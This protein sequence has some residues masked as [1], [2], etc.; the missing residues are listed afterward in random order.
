[1]N[2]TLGLLCVIC[3]LRGQNIGAEEPVVFPDANLKLA[4]ETELWV[5]DAMPSDMLLLTTLNANSRRISDLT[6][7]EYALNLQ[8]LELTHNKI[9]VVSPLMNLSFLKKLVLNNNKIQDLSPLSSLDNLEHLDLHENDIVDLSPLSSLTGLTH[10]NLH[11]NKISNIS[12]LSDLNRLRVLHLDW[13]QIRDLSGLSGLV[14]L[15]TL[16]LRVNF[17]RNISPL[18]N[19]TQ[20]RTLICSW[21]DVVDLTPLQ[22]LE[23]L[24]QLGLED[25]AVR[26]VTALQGLVKLRILVLAECPLKDISPLT[27]LKDLVHLDVSS[28][29]LN[30]TAYSEDMDTIIENNPGMT[31][32]YSPNKH[33]TE[34]VSITHEPGSLTVRWRP[35]SNGPRFTSYYRLC[36][37][38][39]PNSPK[40]PVSPWIKQTMFRDEDIPAKT[41]TYWVQTLATVP[42]DSADS[43]S[44][45]RIYEVPYQPSL[46]LTST[47]GGFYVS[48]IEDTLVYENDTL[49][50]VSA[51]SVDPN[52]YT[53][54]HWSGSAVDANRVTDVNLPET[55]VWVDNSY[56]LRAHFKSALNS[57]FVDVNQSEG[58]PEDGTETHPFDSIQAAIDVAQEGAEIK[59]RPGV[60]HETI[61]FLGKNVT[62]TGLDCLD[63]NQAELPIIDANQTGPVVSFVHGEDSNCLISGFV[64]TRGLG[65]VVCR[66]SSPVVA[67]CLVVGND[68]DLSS[69]EAAIYCQNSQAVF[70]QCTVTDNLGLGFHLEQSQVTL[71]HSIAWHNTR[72]DILRDIYSQPEVTFCN[73]GFLWTLGPGNQGNISE[74][75]LFASRGFWVELHEET[76]WIH[77]DYHLRSRRGRWS[78]LDGVWVLD[79]TDSPCIDA[80]NPTKPAACETLSNR[81][82]LGAYGGTWQAS[83]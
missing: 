23:N 10:L 68:C 15:E 65:G 74:E 9:S 2:R 81:I 53:F 5:W 56:S 25:N 14:N 8:R 79:D 55:T 27:Q 6:G 83:Q 34:I 22:S 57:I 43:I 35:V 36:R 16:T 32:D 76:L 28:C 37:S 38:D 3:L 1:M 26:D 41:Y 63:P 73:T 72:Q 12:P 39:D 80:G 48:P 40:V 29:P 19:L 52:V 70:D 30:D 46:R 31:L 7:M 18:G 45:P 67:N 61:D 50:H 66:D 59:V 77:G 51:Q 42:A 78:G 62:L 24:T 11:E 20:L 69:G 13:N 58:L 4:V 33:P 54:H 44:P 75:P 71:T 49:V 21:N 64:L 82:N 60:Y 17:M 47:L